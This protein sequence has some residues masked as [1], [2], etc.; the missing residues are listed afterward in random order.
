MAENLDILVHVYLEQLGMYIP[1]IY[2]K[3]IPLC[4]VF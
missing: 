1:N 3:S 2:S 4:G